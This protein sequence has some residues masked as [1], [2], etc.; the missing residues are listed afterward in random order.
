MMLRCPPSGKHERGLFRLPSAIFLSSLRLSFLE[1]F[2]SCHYLSIHYFH[3]A[4]TL[5][6][7][8]IDISIRQL[9]LLSFQKIFSSFSLRL[10]PFRFRCIDTE[11]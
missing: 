2:F 10:M 8:F 1:F 7:I 6:F 5:S 4:A 9:S 11:Y 3:F